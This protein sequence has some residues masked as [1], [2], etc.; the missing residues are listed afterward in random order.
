MK[1]RVGQS[2]EWEDFGSASLRVEKIRIDGSASSC[3]L[4]FGS[5]VRTRQM[6]I[7]TMVMYS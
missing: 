3:C 4:V 2:L 6:R 1:L 5:A 7:S